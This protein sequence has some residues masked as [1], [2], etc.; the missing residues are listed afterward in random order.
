M[1]IQVCSDFSRT[2]CYTAARLFGDIHVLLY[3]C[4]ALPCQ[5]CLVRLGLTVKVQQVTGVHSV[6]HTQGWHVQ[7]ADDGLRCKIHCRRKD[8]RISCHCWMCLHTCKALPYSCGCVHVAL[9]L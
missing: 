4:H 8:D 1:S 5:P 2:D 3:C 6:Y 7:C 9:V